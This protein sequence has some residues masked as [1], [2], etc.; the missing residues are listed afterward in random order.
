MSFS[1]LYQV[2]KTLSQ[3]ILG[4]P[5]CP[6]AEDEGVRSVTFK[7]PNIHNSEFMVIF[8]CRKVSC[9]QKMNNAKGL[10]F[11]LASCVSCMLQIR[12]TD[13]TSFFLTNVFQLINIK[14]MVELEIASIELVLFGNGHYLV[15][16]VESFFSFR[17]HTKPTRVRLATKIT[18]ELSVSFISRRDSKILWENST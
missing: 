5:W 8:Q 9:Y 1:L 12:T 2:E 11:L 18:S 15:E 14:E 13:K 6:T 10:R 4:L 7:I 3:R 17:K 16:T